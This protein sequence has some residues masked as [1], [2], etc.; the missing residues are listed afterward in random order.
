MLF[1]VRWRHNG[2]VYTVYSV[3][4]DLISGYCEFLVYNQDE[5]TWEW[6]PADE[7]EPVEE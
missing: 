2:Q 6:L 7:C 5:Y 3:K 1:K 4:D